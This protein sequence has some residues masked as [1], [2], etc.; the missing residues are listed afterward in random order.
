M[1]NTG[2][3]PNL[4]TPFPYADTIQIGNDV[5]PGQATVIHGKMPSDW[6]ERKGYGL[7]GATLWPK[8]DPLGT[9]S[10]RFDLWDEN[11]YASWLSFYKK[12][13]SPSAKLITPGSPVPAALTILHPVLAQ[14]GMQ[15][16]VVTDR[17]VLTKDDTG[18]WTQTIDFKQYRKPKPAP[19]PA[20]AVIPGAAVP[21]PT[22]T[23]QLE[24]TAQARA[25]EL[26]SLVGH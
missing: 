22:A 3:L 6:D 10:I 11:S 19:Q 7:A 2:T 24:L 20:T 12:Y 9:F 5:S 13:F 14:A 15:E 16:C 25:A 18:L 8:G 23:S 21:Q 1:S 4:S 17:S 26:Q